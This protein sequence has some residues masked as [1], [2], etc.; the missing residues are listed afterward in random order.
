M[1]FLN[2]FLFGLLVILI[3]ISILW[4]FSLV[5]KDSSIIDIF[6]GT[7][8]VILVWLYFS[9]SEGES[10][11]KWLIAILVTIWGLRLSL[12]LAYRNIGKGE[13]YR[14][15]K[16]RQEAGNSWWWR[17]FFKV[18]LLQSL[19]MCFVGLPLLGVQYGGSNLFWLDYLAI[20]VWLIGFVFEAGGDWQLMKFRADANNKGKV[21]DYGLWRYTRH[22]NYFGDA[23]QWWAFYLIALSAGAW[24]TIISPIFMSL[25]LMRV[26]GVTLL[27]HSLKKSKV[28]YQDY[29]ERSSAFFP[30]PPKKSS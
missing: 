11:R 8:F 23:V 15:Q 22:P 14:Y 16:W 27:E 30:M 26:S 12:Y 29:I 9:L 4:L 24:W 7:G 10:N 19:T 20:V 1:I 18:F 6:W 13:D 2:I 5:L 3:C 21:L 25:L 17:S 28:E